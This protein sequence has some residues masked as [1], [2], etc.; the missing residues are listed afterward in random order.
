MTPIALALLI[1]VVVLVAMAQ[2][3]HLCFDVDMD[4][5]E[6]LLVTLFTTCAVAAVAFGMS[7]VVRK[8]TG[9]M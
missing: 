7:V 1:G 5:P 8:I 4:W 2:F 6:A 3:A 9:G